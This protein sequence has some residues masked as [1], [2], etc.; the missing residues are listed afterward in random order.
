MLIAD[1]LILMDIKL[2]I[3]VILIAINVIVSLYALSNQSVLQRWMMNPYRIDKNKEYYRFLTSGLIHA[4]YMH[5][6]FNMITLYYFGGMVE[7]Y[8]AYIFPGITGSVLYILLYF[9]GM[10]VAD[11]PSF[12]KHRNHPAFNALGASGAVS[13]VLFAGILFQPMMGI[14]IMFIPIPIPGF[15]FG[16]LYLAYSYFQG[17]RGN[18]NIG[19]DAHFF[20]AVFGIVFTIVLHPAALQGFINQVSQFRI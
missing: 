14:G 6:L 19:H 15:I 12:L 17:R 3:T 13:A 1:G 5:L 2:S 7:S 10:V 8:Y 9:V 4:D 16:L 20:G 18:D 11:I